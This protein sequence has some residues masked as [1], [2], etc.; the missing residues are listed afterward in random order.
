MNQKNQKNQRN[1][2]NQKNQRNQKNQKNQRISENLPLVL[3]F[4]DSPIL[5]FPIL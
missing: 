2:K 1:Q 3:C 4:F 5:D